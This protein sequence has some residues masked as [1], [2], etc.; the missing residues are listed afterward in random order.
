MEIELHTSSECCICLECI[1]IKPHISLTCCDNVV[2]TDCIVEWVMYNG[3]YTTCPLCKGNC[4]NEICEE[5]QINEFV[6]AVKDLTTIKQYSDA[7]VRNVN[8]IVHHVYND[9][10]VVDVDDDDKGYCN[11]LCYNYCFTSCVLS[12]V[13]L[14]LIVAFISLAR[15]VYT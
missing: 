15:V 9:A 3:L 4:I 2:H 8:L 7:H 12:F 1:Q 14:V 6:L 5:I 11:V 13:F 10:V